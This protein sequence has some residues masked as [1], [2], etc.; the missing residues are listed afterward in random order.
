MKIPGL[1]LRAKF[2][3]THQYERISESFASA[4]KTFISYALRV[5]C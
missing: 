5:S 2:I 4:K 3:P 1:F